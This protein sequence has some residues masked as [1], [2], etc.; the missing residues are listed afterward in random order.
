MSKLTQNYRLFTLMQSGE[1]ITKEKIQETLGVSMNSVPVY[2][3]E[4]KRLYKAEIEVVRDGR[5]VT[6][7]KLTNKI[8]V[9]Q[10]RTNNAQAP[11]KVATPAAKA[12]GAQNWDDA[13]LDPEAGA[14]GESEMSDI[15]AS[16][17]VDL[18]FGG[19]NEGW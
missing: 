8:K 7:Y 19:N 9:P 17:M 11:E 15:K 5:K 18:P 3:H 2:I 1:V 13:V 16:L 4:L 10:F 6:G 12:P 14:I